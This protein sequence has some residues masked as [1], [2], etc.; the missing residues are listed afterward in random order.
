MRI[1]YPDA[2]NLS[3]YTRSQAYLRRGSCHAYLHSQR[4]TPVREHCTS[5]GALHQFGR[6]VMLPKW[7]NTTKEQELPRQRHKKLTPNGGFAPHEPPTRRRRTLR[8]PQVMQNPH[9]SPV[10]DHGCE[11]SGLRHPTIWIGNDDLDRLISY[12]DAR[13]LSAS[14]SRRADRQQRRRNT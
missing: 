3:G 1:T 8:T 13:N 10:D 7:C 12:P 14:T 6:G 11:E 5:S 2:R 4:A 9:C